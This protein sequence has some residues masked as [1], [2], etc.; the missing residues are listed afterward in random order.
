MNCIKGKLASRILINTILM[1]IAV[2]ILDPVP[3]LDQAKASVAPDPVYTLS[4]VNNKDNENLQSYQPKLSIS[5]IPAIFLP[6]SDL[7]V[8]AKIEDEFGKIQEATLGY[9]INGTRAQEVKMKLINGTLSKGEYVASIPGQSLGTNT[10]VTVNFRDDLGYET[11]YSKWIKV[12]TDLDAPK[13][14]CHTDPPQPLPWQSFRLS[15]Y[16]EDKGSGVMKVTY[17]NMENKNTLLVLSPT[18]ADNLSGQFESK[19]YHP[20][21]VSI[22]STF[23]V[24]AWDYAGNNNTAIIKYNSADLAQYLNFQTKILDIDIIKMAVRAELA[25]N[26]EVNQQNSTRNGSP[27]GTAM[28]SSDG[29]EEAIEF[30]VYSENSP[31]KDGPLSTM[32]TLPL[33]GEPWLYPF[34]K[35]STM[36]NL[37][38]PFAVV[39]S[40]RSDLIMEDIAD[41]WHHEVVR[42]KTLYCSTIRCIE[43]FESSLKTDDYDTVQRIEI[44]FSRNPY[45]ALGISLPLFAIFYLLGGIFLI[46]KHHDQLTNKLAISIGAFVF[47]FAFT[48]VTNSLKPSTGGIPTIADLMIFSAAIATIGYSIGGIFETHY[49]KRRHIDKFVLIAVSTIIVII[50]IFQQGYPPTLIMLILSGMIGGL[51]YGML[52]RQLRPGKLDELEKENA[53]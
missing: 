24:V 31:L 2:V 50:F 8:L 45:I 16:I 42:N 52:V 4:F 41:Y 33:E 11:T 48:E 7:A 30:V 28:S 13:L 51:G 35:Y 40:T 19:E 38:V 26:G 12:E 29:R 5:T 21:D 22:G 49:K 14:E 34:D 39:K 27:Y 9:S 32:L 43:N 10:Y 17:Y 53:P 37:T 15:C 20:N 6:N 23:S 1:S 46:Q 3:I 47:I 44:A 18:L 36:T 25:V